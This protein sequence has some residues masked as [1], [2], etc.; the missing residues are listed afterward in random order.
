MRF[1][2]RERLRTGI[3][4]GLWRE[5]CRAAWDSV[6]LQ[7]VF[8]NVAKPG[9]DMGSPPYSQLGRWSAQLKAA[10]SRSGWRESRRTNACCVAMLRHMQVLMFA[11]CS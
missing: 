6:A 7:S 8:G 2:G 1:W 4:G 10:A 5:P 3:R 9:P 11:Q